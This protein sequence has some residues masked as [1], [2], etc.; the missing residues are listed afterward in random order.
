MPKTP[1][2]NRFHEAFALLAAAARAANAA[3]GHRAPQ[4]RDLRTLGIDPAAYKRM[5]L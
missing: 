1:M 2:M 4:A 5:G 3:E